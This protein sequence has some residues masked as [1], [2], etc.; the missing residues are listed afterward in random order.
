MNYT[1]DSSVVVNA[2]TL[3][4]IGH[5]ESDQVLE[6]LSDK[7]IRVISP[8]LLLVEVAASIARTQNDTKLGIRIADNLK[9]MISLVLIP[10]NDDLTKESVKIAAKY[11]LRGADAVYVA[12]CRKYGTALITR[13]VE[14][15][16]R[17]EQIIS[18][19]TPAEWLASANL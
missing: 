11:R 7:N 6:V 13:D 18:A 4:E 12:V 3:G 15:Y 9:N 5:S 14:Q 17:S 1:L 16:T 19:F 8:T 10:L 2:Y